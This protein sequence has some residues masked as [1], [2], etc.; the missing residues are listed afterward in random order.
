MKEFTVPASVEEL[1]KVLDFINGELEDNNCILKTQMQ[2]AIAVEEIF[3][4]ISN[5]A[6]NPEVGKATIKI[7]VGGE[8]L[9]VTIQFLDGGKSYNPLEKKDPDITKSA[10]ER[11]IGGL[12][13]YIVKKSMDDV[14]YEYKDGMNLLTIS[15][16]I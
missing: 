6:Y 11:D 15:K 16:R 4:N 1:E 2:V 9:Q 8:P 10:D 3:V 7:S 13:I 14:Q 5:Y 12:G